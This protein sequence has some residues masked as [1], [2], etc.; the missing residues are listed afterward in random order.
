MGREAYVLEIF[1]F[2]V[3]LLFVLL[4]LF[5][6]FEVVDL[7]QAGL[8]SLGDVEARLFQLFLFISHNV[9]VYCVLQKILLDIWIQIYV[10]FFHH[11]NRRQ[12]RH[13]LRPRDAALLRLVTL[14]PTKYK[15]KKSEDTNLFSS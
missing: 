2:L 7:N 4:S 9:P 1:D 3:L 6:G 11:L 8:V 13:D 15:Y 5:L 10:F 14:E 12:L